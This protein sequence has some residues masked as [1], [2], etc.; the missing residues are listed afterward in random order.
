MLL[1]ILNAFLGS[2]SAFVERLTAG[3]PVVLIRDGQIDRR[4]LRRELMHESEL[5]TA[6]RMEQVERLEDVQQAVLECSG[7]VSVLPVPAAQPLKRV[8]F[9]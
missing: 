5:M 7:E 8:I 9:R 2:R 4:A 6:L 3:T 1:H